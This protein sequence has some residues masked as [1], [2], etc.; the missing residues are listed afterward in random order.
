[1]TELVIQLPDDLEERARSAGLLTD[2]AIQ[3]LLEEAMRRQAGRRLRTVV[4]NI[5][6]AGINP[7]TMQEIDA[8]V[9]AV[10][11]ERRARQAQGSGADRP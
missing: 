6:A 10:R 8:E 3:A 4:E 9:K 1:M 5:H 11:A 7:M 2:S